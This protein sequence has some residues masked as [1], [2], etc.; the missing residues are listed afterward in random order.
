MDFYQEKKNLFKPFLWTVVFL[1]KRRY[2]RTHVELW[3]LK[4]WASL[5]PSWPLP[6]AGV[7]CDMDVPKTIQMVRS[8]RSGMV[9]TEAQYRFIY[10]AVKHYIETLQ[11]RIEEEQVS[12]GPSP[13]LRRS[14]PDANPPPPPPLCRKARS[15]DG[16]TPTSSTRCPTWPLE[17]RAPWPPAPPSPPPPAQSEWRRHELPRLGRLLA[18]HVC[19]GL[20]GWGTTAPEST[21]TWA[22]CSSRRASDES[23]PRPRGPPSSRW[24]PLPQAGAGWLCG[25]PGAWRRAPSA[26]F[27]YPPGG[28]SYCQGFRDS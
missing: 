10:M 27:L 18:A 17:S 9:Q 14:V 16:S 2:W 28:F 4:P 1:L 19:L 7:D 23:R 12:V 22:W 3:V 25:R 8:K 20:S 24:T 6:P 13:F 11:R 26:P 21:R 15:K 5:R